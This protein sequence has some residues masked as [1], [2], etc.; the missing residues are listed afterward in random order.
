MSDYLWGGQ[1]KNKV[2]KETSKFLY[3]QVCKPSAYAT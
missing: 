3:L 2:G 1:M